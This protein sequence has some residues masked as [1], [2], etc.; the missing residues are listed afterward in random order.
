MTIKM[1]DGQ[2]GKLKSIRFDKQEKFILST[3]D[4]GLMFAHQIDKENIK[5][6]AAFEPL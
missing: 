4:D 2:V 1:H 6:E 3:A 5:R